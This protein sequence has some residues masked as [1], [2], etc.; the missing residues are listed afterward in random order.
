MYVTPAGRY[1][2]LRRAN[3]H[4]QDDRLCCDRR[5]ARAHTPRCL[6]AAL[7]AAFLP[8]PHPPGSCTGRESSLQRFSSTAS[9]ATTVKRL[10]NKSARAIQNRSLS[11]KNAGKYPLKGGAGILPGSVKLPCTVPVWALRGTSTRSP[12]ALLRSS[13]AAT[14]VRAERVLWAPLARSRI[15]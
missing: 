12:L 7:S 15:P 2:S 8:G 4:V 1:S 14:E 3:P 6:A 11:T 5:A 9:A 10:P 13:R